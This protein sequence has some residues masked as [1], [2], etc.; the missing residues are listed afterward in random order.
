MTQNGFRERTLSTRSCARCRG[1]LVHDWCYDLDNTGNF[2]AEF[3][4][5]AQCWHRVD[6]VILQNQI[7]PS[8]ES[9]SIRQVRQRYI[10]RKIRVVTG[11]L[12]LEGESMSPDQ[13]KQQ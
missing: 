4:R 2:N 8:V 1:L 3:I 12:T 9:Q 5:C 7:R 11:P 13:L 6:P 10:A